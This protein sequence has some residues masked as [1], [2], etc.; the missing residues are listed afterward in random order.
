MNWRNRIVSGC[1]LPVSCGSWR[2][3]SRWINCRISS[4]KQEAEESVRILIYYRGSVVEMGQVML[5]RLAGFDRLR[6]GNTGVGER[7]HV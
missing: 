3:S 4:S 7:D 6:D 2:R 5:D 1:L